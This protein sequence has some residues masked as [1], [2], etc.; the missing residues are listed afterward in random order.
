MSSLTHHP[1]RGVV[2]VGPSLGS[3]LLRFAVALAAASR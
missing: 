1:D 2:Y 3:S